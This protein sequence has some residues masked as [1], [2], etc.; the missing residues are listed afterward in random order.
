MG[1]SSDL[2]QMTTGIVLIYVSLVH[3]IVPG[4]LVLYQVLLPGTVLPGTV[5]VLLDGFHFSKRKSSH[6]S[7]SL[8]NR[9]K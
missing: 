9:K 5:R 8:F 1:A 3:C 6:L 2:S 7:K 4:T